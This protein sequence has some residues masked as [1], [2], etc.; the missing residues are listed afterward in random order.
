MGLSKPLAI[1]SIYDNVMGNWREA[2][3]VT[4]FQTQVG[5]GFICRD[6]LNKNSYGDEWAFRATFFQ[7]A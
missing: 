1:V 5:K 2:F 6:F 4:T 3:P 7:R